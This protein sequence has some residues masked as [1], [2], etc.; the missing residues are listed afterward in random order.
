[1]RPYNSLYLP[2]SLVNNLTDYYLNT[3]FYQGTKP[4][5]FGGGIFVQKAKE[6]LRPGVADRLERRLTVWVRKGH[7]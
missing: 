4:E 7:S 5:E 6:P 1:M 2:G 3:F